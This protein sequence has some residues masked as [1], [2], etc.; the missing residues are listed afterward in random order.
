MVSLDAML[1]APTVYVVL[2]TRDPFIS[3]LEV[4]YGLEK[5]TKAARRRW[6][7]FQYACF[8]E[9]TTGL[10]ERSGGL[11]RLH[12]NLL[13]KGVPSEALGA[14]DRVARATWC[15]RTDTTQLHVGPIY[16]ADGLCKYVT[17]LALHVAKEGQRPPKSYAGDL[18]RWTNGYFADGVRSQR[19]QARSVLREKRALWRAL[20][21]G[22]RGLEA[23]VVAQAD[24]L[25]QAGE[26]WELHGVIESIGGLVVSSRPATS[27]RGRVSSK[28]E[29]AFAHGA[30]VSTVTG[31][32][33]A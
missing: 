3:T 4:Q 9:F 6:P 15:A 11:R 8:V 22:L 25:S 24:V 27:D 5:L 14:L 26:T 30:I 1:Y 13:V 16:A 23:E 2:T 18:V 33:F 20:G 31:E 32:V 12:L 29:L 10:S 19:A 28:S 17:N 7:D 21:S